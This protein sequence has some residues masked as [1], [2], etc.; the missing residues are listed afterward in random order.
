MCRGECFVVHTLILLNRN[1]M[2][3]QV[4]SAH[5]SQQRS[6]VWYGAVRCRALPCGAALCFLSNIQQYQVYDAKYQ[7]PGAGMY[8]FLYSSSSFL[9]SW[10]SFLG[11][12]APTPPPQTTPALSIRM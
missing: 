7:V 6:A 8:V 10:L 4:S 5:S 1:K 12:Y 3:P 9:Q 11:P 2:H